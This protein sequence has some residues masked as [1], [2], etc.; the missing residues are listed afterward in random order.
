M[1]CFEIF[2]NFEPMKKAQIATY[3]TTCMLLLSACACTKRASVEQVSR[4]AT[5]PAFSS[6][7]AYQNVAQQ[8]AFGPRIPHSTGHEQCA[9][10]LQKELLRH[11]AD[12]LFIQQTDLADFGPMTNIMG[13]FNLAAPKRILLLAHWDTRPWADNDPDPANHSTPIDGANDGGSGVGV[14]LELARLIGA[15]KPNVGVDIL[16][17]DA[18]DSG[19][20]GDDSSWA[21]G[22]QYFAEHMP[23]GT[24]E[25]LPEC[26]ILLDMVGGQN[27]TFP[28]EGFSQAY[29]PAVVNQLWTAAK[30]IN[31]SNRFPNATGGGINDDHIPLLRA[32]IPT[33]DI[34]ES[35][36]PQTGGF[37]PAWHTLAD[38]LEHIDKGTLGDVGT[39]LTT[40][41]YDY[42]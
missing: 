38:N 22:A 7:S 27:A 10:W 30:K 42:K 3:L 16:F 2:R 33:I 24:N 9:Q 21:R 18:E 35:R 8:V 41:I 20:E 31:L 36:H 39:L 15:Q 25:P 17:V 12:T 14:L 4:P 23:Y 28:R 13:R 11:G 29:A 40:Y 6:D 37:N 5:I 1:T 19:S 32:G 26:A 34:I